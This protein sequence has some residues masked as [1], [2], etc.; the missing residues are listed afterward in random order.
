MC[1]IEIVSTFIQ[2][3]WQTEQ[4]CTIRINEFHG[5]IA[6]CVRILSDVKNAS[7]A[8]KPS[9]SHLLFIVKREMLVDPENCRSI[10]NSMINDMLPFVRLELLNKNGANK[11]S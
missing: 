11:N 1:E 4:E 9:N 3:P 2:H 6:E 7:A 10:L 5:A 8:Q